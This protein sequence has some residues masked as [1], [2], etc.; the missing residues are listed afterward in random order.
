VNAPV[1]S[2]TVDL[3]WPA[4]RLIV[5]LDGYRGHGTRAAFERDRAR[6]LQLKLL[7]YE[8][9]RLTWRQLSQQPLDVVTSIRRCLDRR[10]LGGHG[11]SG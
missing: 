4:Q 1:D 3:L 2:F 8:V 9:I 10:G 11:T 5:E 7:G 6:D